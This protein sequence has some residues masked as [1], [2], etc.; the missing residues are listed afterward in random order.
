MNASSR[1][2]AIAAAVLSVAI[3]A[4]GWVLGIS[5]KL[6]EAVIADSQRS[7]VEANNQAQEIQLAKIKAQ[8]ENIED[9]RSQLAAL[10]LQ[11]PEG[12]DLAR[13]VGQLHSLEQSTGANVESI[14]ASEPTP[15]VAAVDGS[16][17]AVGNADLL[18]ADKF[19]VIPVAISVSGTQASVMEFVSGLQNGERLFLVTGLTVAN[20]VSPTGDDAS[21]SASADSAASI[22]G[23]IYV[24]LDGTAKPENADTTP[25]TGDSEG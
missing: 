23:Y 1:I 9:L 16:L 15:F 22:S 12:D 14:T 4:L 11:V 21:G 6:D 20:G 17:P 3:A 13:F 24:L 7:A 25:I 2:W 19:I 18:T 5:P 8:Y 10:R